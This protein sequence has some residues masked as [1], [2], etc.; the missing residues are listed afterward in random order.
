[1]WIDVRL[2]EWNQAKSGSSQSDVEENIKATGHSETH[3]TQKGIG[4]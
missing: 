3:R 1:M 4:H 2:F